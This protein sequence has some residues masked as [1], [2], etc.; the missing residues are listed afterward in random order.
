[1][2]GTVA[3]VVCLRILVVDDEAGVRD[4]TAQVLEEAGFVV[5]AA[6]CV[7][8]AEALLRD[9]EEIDLLITDV[10]MPGRGGVELARSFSQVRPRGKVLFTTGYTRYIE[11]ERLAD[12]EILDKPYNRE[13]LL[14]AV[15]RL[16]AEKVA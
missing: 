4:Y 5:R 7:E 15:R 12:A 9:G 1:L 13:A 14:H 11:P 6:A 10:V 2:L 8:D 16:L 3:A